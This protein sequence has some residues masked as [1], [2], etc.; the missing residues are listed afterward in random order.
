MNKGET[1]KHAGGRPT[2][3]TRE[4]VDKAATYIESHAR[5]ELI[6]EV[7]LAIFLDVALSSVKLWGTKETPLGQEFSA[8]LER[9]NSFQHYQAL[10]KALT[11]E[12]KAPIAQLVLANHGYVQKTATDLTTNGKEMPAPILGGLS[13]ASE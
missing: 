11:G 8:T 12:Y 6:S 9:I 7:G 2:K 3:L 4:L 1:K 10:N 13:K 5:F